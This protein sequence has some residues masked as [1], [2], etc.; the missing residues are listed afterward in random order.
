MGRSALRT[1]ALLLLTL[2]ALAITAGCTHSKS[3]VPTSTPANQEPIEVVSVTGPLPPF[4]PGGPNVEVTLQNVSTQ[5][6]S[7][8]SARLELSSAINSYTFNFEVTSSRPLSPGASVTASQTLIGAGFTTSTTY[9]LTIWG[10][11]GSGAFFSYTVQI[12][13]SNP[14]Q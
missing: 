5:I 11:T 3:P 8:L 1:A 4:N 9:P 2:A 7:S 12:Q 10:T 14:Q 13:I 6:V